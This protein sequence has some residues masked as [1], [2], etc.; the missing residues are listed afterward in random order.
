MS[1]KRPGVSGAPIG[2]APTSSEKE[3]LVEPSSAGGDAT[4]TSSRDRGCRRG[5]R[6]PGRHGG[7]IDC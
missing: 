2:L 7:K 6:T 1:A 4:H 3:E 5:T